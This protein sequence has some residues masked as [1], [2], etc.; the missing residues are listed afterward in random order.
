[1][2]DRMKQKLEGEGGEIQYE[3]FDG[4]GLGVSATIF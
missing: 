1:M 4:N 3:V 2:S